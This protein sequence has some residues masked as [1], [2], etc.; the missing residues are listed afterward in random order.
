MCWDFLFTSLSNFYELANLK[1]DIFI[2]LVA[3][4][5][6][7]SLHMQHFA[8]YVEEEQSR[9]VSVFEDETSQAAAKIL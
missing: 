3:L 8:L 2:L 5:V 6:Y 1:M 4:C 7:Q 9:G